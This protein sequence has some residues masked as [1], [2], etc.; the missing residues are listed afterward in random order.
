MAIRIPASTAS[1][2]RTTNL[3]SPSTGFTVCGWARLNTL[4]AAG[5]QCLWA[6]ED[7]TTNAPGY[8]SF[9][10]LASG[11]AAIDT[12]PS[13]AFGDLGAG[14]AAGAWFFWYVKLDTT[15]TPDTFFCGYR[16]V[17]GSWVTGSS[18][19]NISFTSAIMQLG[20][21]SYAEWSDTA[22]GPFKHWAATL[23]ADEIDAEMERILP[24]RYANLQRF[25][26]F[27]TV[28]EL[29]DYS[30]NAFTW[31]TSGSPTS[32]DAPPV[33]WGA[34]RVF[35]LPFSGGTPIDIFAEV[36]VIGIAQPA[37]TILAGADK[38]ISAPVDVVGIAQPA[39]TV[40]I[41]QPVTFLAS[42]DVIGIADPQAVAMVAPQA[43]A[44][45]TLN[46]GNPLI[47]NGPDATSALKAGPRHVVKV[48][49]GD[50]RMLY[51]AASAGGI[52]S[53]AYATSTDGTAWTKYNSGL[54]VFTALS[55]GWE[56]DEASIT[57]FLWD[58]AIEKWIAYYH[59][60]GNDQPRLIRRATADS[61][62][63]TWTRES[64]NPVLD[65]GGVGAWDEEGVA[66]AKVMKI[67]NVYHMFYASDTGSGISIGHATS[68]DGI[69]WTK[70]PANPV[71]EGSGSGWDSWDAQ[72]PG[73]LRDGSLFHM[74]YVGDPNDNA[75]EA[76][77]YAYSADG[78]TWVRGPN[79]P[80]LSKPGTANVYVGDTVD[81]YRDGNTY[82]VL[83]GYF[84]FNAAARREIHEA[85]VTTT[86][87]D[88]IVYPAC[89]KVG[90]HDPA[91]T[92]S[93]GAG[94]AVAAA[95]DVIGIA[96][97][98]ATVTAL[99]AV[100]ATPAVDVLGV[101]DPGV[102]VTALQ[103]ATVAASVDVVGISD[104]SV[105]VTVGGAVSVGAGVDAVAVAQPAVTVIANRVLTVT[106]SVDVVGVADP[107]VTVVAGV[108]VTFAAGVDALAVA[109]PQAT[110]SAGGVITVLAGVDVVALAQ[111]QATVVTAQAV[112]FA[113]AVDAIAVVQLAPGVF[114]TAVS[115][116]IAAAVDVVAVVQPTATVVIAIMIVLKAQRDL[117]LRTGRDLALDAQ[118]NKVLV[119]RR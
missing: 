86:V 108:A 58:N 103:A 20:N 110:V 33:S 45:L 16:T 106:A 23:T 116:T 11:N 48:G 113:A 101:A 28:A 91:A 54:P 118:R 102:T 47:T 100:T 105:T 14:P 50:Y 69:D 89:D 22:I 59:G 6:L 62:T 36:D 25:S 2:R 4:S 24:A 46:A 117:V 67:A 27:R 104:P 1:I 107:A 53:T 87:A 17:G 75:N 81:A 99:Q 40:V 32:T 51:E 26:P 71:F 111:P 70:D 49:N 88:I 112:T 44:D 64:T 41:Q 38:I 19:A 65:Q 93:V 52:G 43:S 92:V 7:S 56:N 82:R 79:N 29:T 83:Y 80:V 12:N 13:G 98:A 68:S 97:P 37:V 39:V 78:V 30:G 9:G 42:V 5:F 63:G 114:T 66:D 96:D 35:T 74:W 18:Q 55:S 95:V 21:N 57:T 15:T 3:P 115:V 60:G 72:S 77:G 76:L 85:T 109:Q 94:V 34:Q 8:A 10:W 61:L 84:N 73:V 31:T 90:I 119:S